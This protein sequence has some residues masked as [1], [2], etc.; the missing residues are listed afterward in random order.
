MGDPG[1]ISPFQTIGPM[2]GYA[3]IFA[4]CDQAVDPASVGALTVRGRVLDGAGEPVA[5]PDGLVELWRGEQW[6]RSRT[7]PDGS[8]AVVVGKPRAHSIEGVGTEAPYLNVT[9]FARGLL[10]AIQTRVY[11]PEETE[12]NAADP[13]M[14]LVPAERRH[15]LVGR[16]DGDDL[17]F[18]VRLQGDEETVFFDD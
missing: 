7:G 11:F 12:A 10:R 9:I 3:L 16:R 1:V 18:D 15:T 14:Q 13:A 2:W 5:Y 6:A 4:G 8:Y 17:V